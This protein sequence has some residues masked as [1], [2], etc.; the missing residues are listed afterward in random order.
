MDSLPLMARDYKFF[1]YA[2][3]AALESDFK[4]TLGAV[5][6]YNGKVVA[7]A[8]SSSKTHSLQAKYNIYRQFEING[9]D[10]LPKVHAEVK[11]ISKLRR[12]PNIDFRRVAIY[13][14]R[15]CKSRPHGLA[16]PCRACLQA[17]KDMN[18][19][20]LFYTTDFGYAHE[21]INVEDLG[22]S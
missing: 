21:R 2:K 6:V 18:I 5:A 14:Y 3:K 9:A 11:L 15:I 16:R 1:E 4:T 17:I 10:C 12:V 19:R 8:A 7:S 22:I 13:I 20:N